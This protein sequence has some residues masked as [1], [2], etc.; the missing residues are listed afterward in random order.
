M[1]QEYIAGEPRSKGEMWLNGERVPYYAT[2]PEMA[3]M[4]M[5]FLEEADF[6]PASGLR[7][8][9]AS[10]VTEEAELYYGGSK[11]LDEVVEVIQNRVQLMLEENRR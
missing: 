5:A 3:G 8:R 9:V 2:S 11:S 1:E 7:D 4:V 10:I 6:T